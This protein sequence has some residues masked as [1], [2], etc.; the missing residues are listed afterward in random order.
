MKEGDKVEQFENLCDVATDKLFTQIPAEDH[1]RIHKIYIKEGDNCQ[2]GELL[3]DLE[4][5]DDTAAEP[6]NAKESG[7]GQAHSSQVTKTEEVKQ[8]SK[9]E[10]QVLAS[11]FVRNLAKSKGL[12]LA[13]IK[14]RSG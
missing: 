1:G 5:D 14:V 11:P 13:S 10:A 9:S 2:V 6:N 3:L 8:Q 4:L 7:Q 12:D